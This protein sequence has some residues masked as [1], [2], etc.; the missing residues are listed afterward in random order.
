MLRLKP[1]ATSGA[2]ALTCCSCGGGAIGQS[3]LVAQPHSDKGGLLSSLDAPLAVGGTVRPEIRIDLKGSTPPPTHMIS[4]RP[5][6][7]SVDALG[8]TGRAPGLAALLVATDENVVIDFVHVWVKPADRIELHAI[9]SSGMDVGELTESVD[10]AVGE[11]LRIVPRAYAGSQVLSGA[12]STTWSIEPP[13]A[14]ALKEGL[15]QRRRILARTPGST[16]IRVSALGAT[17]TLTLKVVP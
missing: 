15:P 7:L 14:L 4:V 17:K 8:V 13:I 16:T 9:D 6:I 1:L 12:T 5:D 2:L 10:L 11:S 3:S